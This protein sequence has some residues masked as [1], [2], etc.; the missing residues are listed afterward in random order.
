M[1][2]PISNNL[3]TYEQF[4]AVSQSIKE[5]T[6]YNTEYSNGEVFYFS[7]SA[8]HSR[9]IFNIVKML[10]DKLPNNCLAISELHIKFKENEYR[11]PDISVFCGK[12]IKG[13][14]ENDLLHLET[15]KLI[16]EVLSESTEKNDRE[17]KMELYAIKGIEEYLLVDY[18]TKAIEQ[19]YLQDNVYKLNK[20]Y[21]NDDVCKLLLYPH[22]KFITGE[23]FELFMQG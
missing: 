13:K 1:S 18:R 3:L 7:P 9:S 6:G 22:I 16:F 20:K 8:K 11:I 2:L 19:Y 4:I 12:D 17:Y 23:I 21:E 14:F 5:N 10:D 15:P